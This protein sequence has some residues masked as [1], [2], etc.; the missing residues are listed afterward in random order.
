MNAETIIFGG[1]ILAGALLVYAAARSRME[2]EAG[3]VVDAEREARRVMALD[4]L[5]EAWKKAKGRGVAGYDRSLGICALTE[6]IA[7]LQRGDDIDAGAAA[8]ALELLGLH[9]EKD[10]DGIITVCEN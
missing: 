1:Q 5:S 9:L 10:A 3:G 6:C 8:T 2:K 7:R 4:L